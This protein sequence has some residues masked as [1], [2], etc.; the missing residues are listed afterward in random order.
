[1][2]YQ[3]QDSVL[4]QFVTILGYS[5]CLSAYIYQPNQQYI[6]IHQLKIK[7]TENELSSFP[8][9]NTLRFQAF[10]PLFSNL[11]ENKIV[12]Y[13]RFMCIACLENIEIT[14]ERFSATAILQLRI[15]RK[16]QSPKFFPTKPWG[17]GSV[18]SLMVLNNN[19]ISVP[20]AGW[21]I[22]TERERVQTV[23]QCVLKSNFNEA[24]KLTRYEN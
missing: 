20:Y 7:Y 19:S 10:A 2:P 15:E 9:D 17:F 16:N 23:E 3:A 6:T 14:P 1:M 13:E 12:Y 4:C 22:W 21:T 11:F 24:L 18:W 5:S 8:G